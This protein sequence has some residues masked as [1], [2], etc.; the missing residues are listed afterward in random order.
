MKKH[1]LFLSLGFT[2]NEQKRIDEAKSFIA[3]FERMEEKLNTYSVNS[4]PRQI[5]AFNTHVYQ[6]VAN[7]WAY[8]RKVLALILRGEI[9]SNNYV[10]LLEHTS[11]EA[12]YFANRLKVLNEGK[13][14]P[15]QKPLL[16][17]PKT[18]I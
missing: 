9:Q 14:K 16:K 8:K 18:Q 4:Y 12:T 3:I 11:K 2:T 1:A 17:H 5:E 7:R 6:A 13:L 10:Q 15:Y